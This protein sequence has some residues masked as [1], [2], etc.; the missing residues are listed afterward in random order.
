MR[1]PGGPDLLVRVVDLYVSSSNALIDTM[2]T[3]SRR[4]DAVT[5]ANAAHA[6]KSSSANVG[7]LAFAELCSEVEA[8]AN[9]GRTEQAL[10]LVKKLVT[11]HRQVLR[12]LDA[13]SAAA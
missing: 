8:A 5:V 6:L 3:A 7:A 2:L 12:A 9:G 13:Q 11:E 4:E 10:G 1:R